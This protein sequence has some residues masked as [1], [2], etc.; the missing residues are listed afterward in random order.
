MFADVAVQDS[1]PKPST[2]KM[3]RRMSSREH[4]QTDQLSQTGSGVVRVAVPLP[5][6]FKV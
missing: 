6:N 5:E 3:T 4:Y 2:Q 1:K